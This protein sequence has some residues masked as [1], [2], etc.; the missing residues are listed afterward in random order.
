MS[1]VPP[2]I[3][4][5]FSGSILEYTR[6]RDN[7]DLT[8]DNRFY[9]THVAPVPFSGGSSMGT[10]VWDPKRAQEESAKP[11]PLREKMEKQRKQH[12]RKMYDGLLEHCRK[13]ADVNPR[14]HRIIHGSATAEDWPRLETKQKGPYEL[15]MI[16]VWEP[17]PYANVRPVFLTPQEE[18][19]WN[20]GVG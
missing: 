10:F 14:A 18:E 1:I 15:E 11:N 6:R 7:F 3:T 5:S 9:E 16:W 13:V 20:E 4:K 8:M 12:M 19:D 2:F 17:D